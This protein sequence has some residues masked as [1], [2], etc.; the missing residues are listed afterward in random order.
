MGTNPLE[1]Q[2]QPCGGFLGRREAGV[3]VGLGPCFTGVGSPMC[4]SV[5]TFVC[6][7]SFVFL[8]SFSGSFCDSVSQFV[9]VR[10]PLPVDLSLSPSVWI[11]VSLCLSPSFVSTS[12]PLPAPP[13]LSLPFLLSV[14]L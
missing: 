10:V 6:S 4:A 8:V 3:N 13:S 7:V 9:S 5:C 1:T 12:F 2:G 11:W 14:S